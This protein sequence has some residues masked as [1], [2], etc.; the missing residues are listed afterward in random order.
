MHANYGRIW[1]TSLVECDGLYIDRQVQNFCRN[2]LAQSP[3]HKDGGTRF[4]QN[5]GTFIKLNG[6]TSM[7][8]TVFPYIGVRIS[9]LLNYLKRRYVV[10]YI[11]AGEWLYTRP[12]DDNGRQGEVHSC[13][14]Y[15]SHG[16]C[17]KEV[18]VV[19][20]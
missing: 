9:D 11:S 16:L 19:H 7:K 12:E 10:Y 18:H 6:I 15:C 17:Q 8:T 2:L 5:F 20:I 13:Y 14:W 1:L 4:H 3:Y